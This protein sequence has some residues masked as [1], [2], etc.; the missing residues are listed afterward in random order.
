[1]HSQNKYSTLRS[2]EGILLN[3]LVQRVTIEVKKNNNIFLLFLSPIQLTVVNSN[4]QQFY[5]WNVIFGN[6][7]SIDKQSESIREWGDDHYFIELTFRITLPTC[8][9][10]SSVA[11]VCRR[12]KTKVKNM[13]LFYT[14]YSVD[15]SMRWNRWPFTFC[16][17]YTYRLVQQ[18]NVVDCPFR[19]SFLFV[20]RIVIYFSVIN[21]NL[22]FDGRHA[23]Y[24]WDMLTQTLER[25]YRVAFIHQT[26]LS[27]PFYWFVCV[28]AVIIW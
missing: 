11:V 15:L 26:I 4:A 12:L 28:W 7:Y 20:V 10:I 18:N 13:F 6:A 16:I 17:M 3:I 19:S 14:V 23:Q 8:W 9:F 1:M 27:P 5:V 24:E 21:T 25:E 2:L 22:W